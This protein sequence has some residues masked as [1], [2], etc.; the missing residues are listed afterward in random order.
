MKLLA[1]K[2]SPIKRKII[3]EGM[4]I[5]E[6]SLLKRILKSSNPPISSKIRLISYIIISLNFEIYKVFVK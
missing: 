2:T 6:E 1:S 3:S 5:L 4:P